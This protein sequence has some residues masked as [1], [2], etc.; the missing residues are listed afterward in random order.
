MA[1][2]AYQRC[3]RPLS[4]DA[5]P[6]ASVDQRYPQIEAEAIGEETLIDEIAHHCEAKSVIIHQLFAVISMIQK[7]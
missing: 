6:P 2:R 3:L 7:H 1:L 4:R 5:G